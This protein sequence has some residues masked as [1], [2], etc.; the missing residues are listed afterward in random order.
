MAQI[1]TSPEIL[2]SRRLQLAITLVALLIALAN[3]WIV[4]KLAPLSQDIAL[5]TQQIQAASKDITE[6]TS[7]H[8][9]LA[10]KDDIQSLDDRLGRIE[11]LLLNR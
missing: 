1:K 10:D 3:V 7:D 2:F 4:S 5:N 8:Q 11:E 6:I 9:D